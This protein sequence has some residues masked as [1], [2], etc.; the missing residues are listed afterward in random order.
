MRKKKLD[1]W[2]EVIEKANEDFHDNK[3]EF[4]VFVGRTSKGIHKVSLKRTSGSSVIST[5]GK[6][7][8]LQEHYERL[9]RASVDDDSWKEHAENEVEEMSYAHRAMRYYIEG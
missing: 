5:K 6:T 2:N 4:W 9:G 8:V 7:E 1:I 3:K